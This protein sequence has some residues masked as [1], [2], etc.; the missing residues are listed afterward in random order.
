M[1]GIL[2][3]GPIQSPP[4][5]EGSASGHGCSAAP[6]V[7]YVCFHT[8]SDR[9]VVPCAKRL[10]KTAG[11]VSRRRSRKPDNSEVSVQFGSEHCGQVQNFGSVTTF[12][13]SLVVYSE[14]AGNA[15]RH[16]CA[17]V[18]ATPPMRSHP[19]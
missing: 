8:T 15:A 18:R 14:K 1:I 4:V 9:L 13:P 3:G 6:Q 5:A 10:K 2:G 17:Q 19:K 12:F 11:R 16:I 7:S